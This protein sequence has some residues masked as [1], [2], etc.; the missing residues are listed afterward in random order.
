MSLSRHR[1]YIFLLALCVCIL[2]PGKTGSA[3][4]LFTDQTPPLSLVLPT[5][6]FHQA[7]SS[8]LPL[9]L[10]QQKRN[11]NLQGTFVVDS[12]SELAI[13]N[14]ILFIQG[15]I[16]GKN[17]AVSAHVG[18]KTIQIKLGQMTLPVSCDIAFRFE[19]QTKTLFLRPKFYKQA[20]RHDPAAVS[21][22]P[23][24]DSMSRE[25]DLPLDQLDPLVGHLGVTP[26]FVQLEPVDIRL[27][28]NALVLQFRPHTG[29]L[30]NDMQ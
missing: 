11:Q 22:A 8:L 15:K 14:N 21:L 16:S 1:Q 19:Q 17:M 10:Q 4:P 5:A 3:Q 2:I 25:Y 12:I 18:G 23:L 9:T 26:F 29:R 28:Q 13:K 20:R 6:T 24:L 30:D 27:S 7:L